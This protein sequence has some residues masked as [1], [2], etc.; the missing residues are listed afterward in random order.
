[1]STLHT[2]FAAAL[3][4]GRSTPPRTFRQW[5]E[6]E[7]IIPD[8][9]HKGER[10]RIER[11]PA[12]GLWIDAV[13][14]P[15]WQDM[16][17]T[18]VT[19]YGKSLFGY[20]SP[21]LYHACELGQSLGFCVP[22]ADMADNKWQADVRPVMESSPN[23]RRMLPTR[24]SGSGGGKVRDMIQLANGAILKIFSAG[25]DDTGKAGFT[26]PTLAI[27]EAAGFSQAGGTSVEADPLRQVRGRQRSYKR[28]KRR[29]Y[30]EGTLTVA[31]E[32]PWSLR[33]AS[34]RSVIV[35]PCPHC[36]DYIAPD[37]EHF[38]GWQNARSEIVAANKA[39]WIC[40]KCERPISEDQ[41]FRSLAHA[42]LLHAGQTIDRRGKVTGPQPESTRLWYHAKPWV[43]CLLGAA[44]IAT[45]EW[46]AAQI[47]ED[48]PE[49]ELSDKELS[50]FV[51]SR[52]Y[53]PPRHD[54]EI[55]ITRDGVAARRTEIA[56]GQLPPDTQLVATGIDLGDRTGWYLSLAA[57]AD[58]RLFV[59]DYGSF[60]VPSDR[61]HPTAA[62]RAA[63]HDQLEYL[64]A[65]YPIIGG[66]AMRSQA[67]WIDS[68]HREEATWQFTREAQDRQRLTQ[69]IMAARG[70]GESQMD[71]R[72][73]T[74]PTKR[75]GTVRKIA[76][77]RTWYIQWMPAPRVFE[78]HWDADRYKWYAQHAM[79]IDVD[80][81]GSIS[82]FAGPEKIHRTLSRHLCNERL[83]HEV[84]PGKGERR[85][86]Y[87][88]GANHL[89]DC[90]AAAYAALCRLGY[91]P[92]KVRLES[93]PGTMPGTEEPAD[94]DA[95]ADS[96][97]AAKPA[98]RRQIV[99]ATADGAGT[100]SP[101]VPAAASVTPPAAPT[102][103]KVNRW[104]RGYQ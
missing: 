86:W 74:C 87:R 60:D 84:V 102:D 5:V 91:Q 11:Q 77:D 92:P 25:A 93:M 78:I 37:R 23:L 30:I 103:S 98:G 44:D 99:T 76:D 51:W 72:K 83:I 100:V 50:Q 42:V 17:F 90:L 62:I 59:P 64:R 56:R 2:E 49:R 47:P 65:G 43:N 6:S 67:I 48:T 22:F 94:S 96:D 88:S 82:L 9:P 4:L 28:H 45:D 75:G 20:V 80:Q 27:T 95:D 63:L 12:I 8:G 36:R 79:S 13:D 19:Q 31:G 57:R 53:T 34:T 16:V 54:E 66:G 101:P 15:Q 55:E 46:L 97:I 26:T 29:T 7:L 39:H 104:L 41:R 1:M 89:L 32:L 61:V 38:V 10:F 58:G 21:T 81:P 24:G 40:P 85:R 73:Y 52:I 35:S 18:A 14:D 33:D 68:G 70:R 3:R 71:S 69:W